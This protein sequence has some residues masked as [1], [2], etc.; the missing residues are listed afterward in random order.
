MMKVGVGAARDAGI[1]A[2]AAMPAAGLLVDHSV[3]HVGLALAD[4]DNAKYGLGYL[5]LVQGE[6]LVRLPCPNGGWEDR[7]WALSRRHGGAEE[8][9]FPAEFWAPAA[10]PSLA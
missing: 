10:A 2:T 5:S 3:G 9:W 8:G 1:T 6:P 7:G 4:F